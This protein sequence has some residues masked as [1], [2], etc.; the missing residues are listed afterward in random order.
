MLKRPAY[1]VGV[2]GVQVFWC[3]SGVSGVQ[4]FW[5]AACE[6]QVCDFEVDKTRVRNGGKRSQH[7]ITCEHC[8]CR[9]HM[10]RVSKDLHVMYDTPGKRLFVKQQVCLPAR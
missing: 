10:P 5:Y 9:F 1:H 7:G 3:V 2:S 4:V 8:G 6:R